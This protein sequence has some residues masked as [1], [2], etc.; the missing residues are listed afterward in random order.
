[1]FKW[2][3]YQPKMLSTGVRPEPKESEVIVFADHVKQGF[4]PPG[5]KFFRDVLH[6]FQLHP[7]D[8]GPNSVSN[9]CNFQV[10]CEVYLQEE[11]SIDLFREYYY[12]NRQ[13]EFTDGPCLELGGISIQRRRD[14]IFPAAALPSHPKDWNRTW[15]YCQD[16]SP[17]DENPL[18]GFCDCWLSPKH[19]LPD[20]I[21]IAER[22][23]Y[24]P[25]FSKV[26]ALLANGL[27]GVDLVR[28]WV[29]WRIIPLSRRT[30][31]MCEYTCDVKD[32]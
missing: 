25:T 30:G 17:A 27:I 28:C 20:R 19:P 12:L 31:L 1:M 29:A 18:P 32:P 15:F 3:S 16:T 13:T 7:Q 14:A 6:F 24:M 2:V 11:P 23:K 5:S 8:I 4:S 22:A 9:I 21:S 10:F 26:R